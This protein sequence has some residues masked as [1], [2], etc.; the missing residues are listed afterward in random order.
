MRRVL[1]FF[2]WQAEQWMVKGR[3][4][5]GFTDMSD[6]A[7]EG[8]SAYALR[9]ASIRR[10]MAEFC[11]NTWKDLPEYMSIGLASIQSDVEE[12]RHMPMSSSQM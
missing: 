4:Q 2:E 3:A 1:V 12:L 7:I 10:A 5:A 6:A 9:Q 8:R 11:R